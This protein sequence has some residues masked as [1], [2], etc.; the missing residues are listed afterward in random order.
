MCNHY[1]LTK[2]HT[3]LLWHNF[4]YKVKVYLKESPSPTFGTISCIGSVK[5]Y[6]KE[7]AYDPGASFVSALVEFEKHSLK[8]Y[9][10]ISEVRNF[11]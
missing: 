10:C 3:H 2:K 1:S 11:M 4:L 8:C 9:L 7:G 5:V 6:L